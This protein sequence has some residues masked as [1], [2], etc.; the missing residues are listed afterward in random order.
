MAYCT[1]DDILLQLDRDTLIQLTDDDNEGKI[2]D[3]HVTAAIADADA[4]IDA[5]CQGRYDI[6]LS[7]VPAMIKK[8]SV[9]MAVYHLYSRRH[10]VP[11]IRKDRYKNAIKFLEKVMKGEI[12]LGA[13]TP[14]VTT[15]NQPV[16]VTTSKDDRTFTMDTMEGF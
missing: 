15:T 1:E 7:P 11:E 16:R 9:D 4:E 14:T 6:P 10:D 3:D 2:I 12:T 8:I 13:T 5:H